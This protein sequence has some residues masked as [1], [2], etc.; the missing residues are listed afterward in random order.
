MKTKRKLVKYLVSLIILVFYRFN[1]K[2]KENKINTKV[3]SDKIFFKHKISKDH[4]E[5]P[6]RIKYII[7]YL[8]KSKLNHLIENV[9]I[10]SGNIIENWI[11]E[12]H[13]NN[14]IKNIKEM[15]PLAHKVSSAAVEI[16]IKGVD[17]IFNSDV[18][19]IFCAVRPPGHHALNTGKEEGF[20]Y[21]NHVA[22]TAKYIQKKYLIDRILIVDWDY[23]HGNSTEYFFYDDPSVLFFSTHDA[24]AY[25]RTGSP[26]RK[27]YGKGLGYN[28]NV[29]L[30]CGT[31]DNEI[32]NAFKNILLPAAE[33]FKP[34]LVII[35]AGFDSRIDDLLGCFKVTDKGFETLT[36]ISMS[37]AKKYCEGKLISVLE[38]GYNLDGN[39]KA[40]ISHIKT[41]NKF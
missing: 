20:C 27:G 37:I 3:L 21:Y 25:P 40:S 1:T 12:I 34:N 13:S 5:T 9:D 38:G 24:S 8:N 41:L 28:I 35:S 30:K 33:K 16:C 31:N 23:H 22:I 7:N 14:H 2:A 11:K 26:S 29:D 32:V 39:A 10:N 6:D 18:R 15:E 19:N 36:E 4:P 17:M